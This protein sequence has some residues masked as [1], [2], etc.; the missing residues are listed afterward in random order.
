[1][2]KTVASY[3]V[4]LNQKGIFLINRLCHTCCPETII[5]IDSSTPGPQLFNMQ[6]RAAISPMLAP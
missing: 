5:D 4:E 6:R 2:E 3:T 1:L